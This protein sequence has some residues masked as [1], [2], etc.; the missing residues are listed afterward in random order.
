MRLLLGAAGEACLFRFRNPRPV[1][2]GGMMRPLESYCGSKR[3]RGRD[4]SDGACSGDACIL[5]KGVRGD[6]GGVVT[7]GGAGDAD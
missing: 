1:F 5:G 3:A 2:G 4:W 7:S 6:P